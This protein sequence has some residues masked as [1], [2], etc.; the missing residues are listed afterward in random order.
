[1]NILSSPKF[2]SFGRHYVIHYF[3]RIEFQHRESPHAHTLLWLAKAPDYVIG[4]ESS[5]L[6][7]LI[8]RVI[9]VSANYASGH[10]NL[11]KHHHTFT[12]YKNIIGNKKECRFE[13]HFMP[14]RSIIILSTMQKEEDG[15][16][17]YFK[18]YKNIKS[19]LEYTDYPDIDPFYFQNNVLLDDHY[20]HILRAGIKRPRVFLRRQPF[21]KWYN[22]FN[23]F[24][25][26]IMTSNMDKQFITDIYSCANLNMSIKAIEVSVTS[27]EKL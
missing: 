16:F 7:E 8:D 25:L 22:L 6:I 11:Q 26:N 9:S 2:R 5:S 21:E 14:S 1:M 3:K 18:H 23:P 4:A 20:H 19:N 10:I 13:A 15:F 27:K 12:C 17:G 24:I